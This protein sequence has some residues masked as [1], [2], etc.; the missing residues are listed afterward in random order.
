[1]SHMAYVPPLTLKNRKYMS[2]QCANFCHF[3][4]VNYS[5]PRQVV[6]CATGLILIMTEFSNMSK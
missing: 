3:G 1:M 4:E 6:H 5:Y 2:K